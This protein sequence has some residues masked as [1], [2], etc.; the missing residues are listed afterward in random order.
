[1]TLNV[2]PHFILDVDPL[3]VTA[4]QVEK[5]VQIFGLFIVL[6]ECLH[7]FYHF[8]DVANDYGECA[9]AYQENQGAQDA[10]KVILRCE[11]T[12]ANCRHRCEGKVSVG[13]G[14]LPIV[15]PVPDPLIFTDE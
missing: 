5:S 15:R 3:I 12:E 1:M 14:V 10:L 13:Q 6:V 7:R 4:D 2:L 8:S 11:I 9:V